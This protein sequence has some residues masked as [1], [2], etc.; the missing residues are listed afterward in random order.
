MST[1]N[2][3]QTTT[4]TTT[5]TF[6]RHSSYPTSI[7]SNNQSSGIFNGKRCSSTTILP[8]SI[9]STYSKIN[10]INSQTLDRQIELNLTG[11]SSWIERCK[12]RVT[13]I[14]KQISKPTIKQGK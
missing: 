10:S 7:N 9:D 6:G 2:N 8:S 14:L 11:N 1:T 3:S 12:Q 5:T 4:T 13:N